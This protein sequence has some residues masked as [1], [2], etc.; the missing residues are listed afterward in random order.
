MTDQVE[1]AA[2][3]ELRDAIAIVLDPSVLLIRQDQ[4]GHSTGTNLKH[5]TNSAS[6]AGDLQAHE[7]LQDAL[8]LCLREGII[9]ESW[10][11]EPAHD[12]LP[13]PPHLGDE[14]WGWFEAACAG[15]DQVEYFIGRVE[16]V[17]PGAD[18]VA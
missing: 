13:I 6:R 2:R 3:D 7:L 9:R 11:P 5:A 14:Y 4:Y 8:R 17:S 15:G 1:G 18:E 16:L 10:E 12:P